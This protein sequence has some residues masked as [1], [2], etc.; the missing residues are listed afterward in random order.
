MSTTDVPKLKRILTFDLMRGYFLLIIIL[1]HL[2]F[3]PNGFG[4][5]TMEGRL[6]VSAAEGFFLISGIVLGIIRGA[7]MVDQPF[8]QVARLLLKRSLQLY[9]TIVILVLLFTFIGW[10][11]YLG[12][13]GLKYNIAPLDT[14]IFSLIWQTLTLQYSY[15]WADYLRLYC[16]FLL[17]SPLA[18][19]MLRR[20]LWYVLMAA[21]VFIWLLF[22]GASDIP[23]ATQELLQPLSW[24]LIFFGGLTVG[25]YWPKI[26]QWWSQLTTRTRRWATWG[27][28]S[29]A[30]LTFI[31][32]IFI[33][34]GGAMLLP[35]GTVLAEQLREIGGTLYRDFFDKEAMPIARIALFSLW[36]SAAFWIF[37]R[38]ERI[39]VRAFGWLLL[40]FGQNSL[41]VYTLHAFIIFF[42]HLYFTDTTL[43]WN[44]L[45]SISIIGLILLAIRHKLLMKIIP[46]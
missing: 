35:V 25:F 19:W 41:Y 18:L 36:F 17:F 43:L 38:F 4:W 30:V 44:F 39:I 8:K 13:P 34:Y 3:Y 46:R 42:V 32:N 10:W 29:L 31:V 5:L 24:Q 27:V 1:N 37:H 45:I 21:S 2:N 22:P 7:K 26:T 11:F 20:G 15:G 6:L 23:S 28:V 14:N 12:N 16:W 9:V 40:P 33:A